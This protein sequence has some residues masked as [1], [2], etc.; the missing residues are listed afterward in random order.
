[1]L[2][3]L[4][5]G[6]LRVI[7][8]NFENIRTGDRYWYER[9]LSKAEIDLVH[10]LTLSNIVKL[11][12]GVTSYPDNAFFSSRFCKGVVKHQCV[13]VDV[14]TCPKTTSASTPSTMAVTSQTFPTDTPEEVTDSQQT[15]P[16]QPSAS[17]PVS[18]PPTTPSAFPCCA[19][20]A[21]CTRLLT[22]SQDTL[23]KAQAN[24]TSALR[25]FTLCSADL[26]NKTVRQSWL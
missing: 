1:M 9:I 17:S 3:I 4:L 10:N 15:F 25:N 16:A 19:A 11:N 5:S 12:S 21:A 14:P 13:P 26:R 23:A 18:S 24:A 7:I 6:F 20:Q 2:P 22:S 8:N